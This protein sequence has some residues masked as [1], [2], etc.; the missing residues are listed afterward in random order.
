MERRGGEMR[1]WLP[2]HKTW[3]VVLPF[4]ELAVLAAA[5]H[6]MHTGMSVFEHYMGYYK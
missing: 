2:C 3:I 5:S 6:P 1:R 4:A